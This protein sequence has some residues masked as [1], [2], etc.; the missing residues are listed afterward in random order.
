VRYP[1]R[2]EVWL[3][4]LGMTAKVRPCLVMSAAIGDND[5]ALITLVPHTTSTRGTPFEAAYKFNSFVPARSTLKASSRFPSSRQSLQNETMHLTA[6]LL[7]IQILYPRQFHPDETA[8]K[9]GQQWM[10][11]I[12]EGQS[13][14]LRNVTIHVERVTDVGDRPGQKN[15]KEVSIATPIKE[16]SV[17]VLLRGMPLREGAVPTARYSGEGDVGKP[18]HITLPNATPTYEL[19]IDCDGRRCPLTLSAGGTLQRLFVFDNAPDAGDFKGLRVIWAGDLDGDGKL[20]LLVDVSNDDNA[21][22][23]ALYLSSKARSGELVGLA[24]ILHTVGC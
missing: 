16:E 19:A 7:A 22:D 18:L 15:G 23:T 11:L 12:D 9:S 20:D 1:V 5:R 17:I 10:A 2:G 8:A 14:A 6:I 4:D 21:G 13:S 24:A 3:V